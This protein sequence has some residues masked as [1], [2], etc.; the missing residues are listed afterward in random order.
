MHEGGGGAAAI[1]GP[2]FAVPEDLEVADVLA[3]VVAAPSERAAFQRVD[4][5]SGRFALLVL[6]G[7]RRWVPRSGRA[8]KASRHG[9]PTSTTSSTEERLTKRLLLD[10]IRRYDERMSEIAYF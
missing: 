5:L 8:T 6:A 4:A 9:A 10:V 7:A 3:D 1:D 2:V